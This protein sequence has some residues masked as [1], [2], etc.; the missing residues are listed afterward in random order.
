[1]QESFGRRFGY[2]ECSTAERAVEAAVQ[3][4]AA[5]RRAAFRW[6]AE[7]AYLWRHAD[8]EG[9]AG[10]LGGEIVHA[11]L[12]VDRRAFAGS[13]VQLEHYQRPKGFS[14]LVDVEGV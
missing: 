14:V 9:R 4:V 6:R 8:G 5:D 7:D 10:G 3:H 1:M 13:D 2:N 12:S 11:T